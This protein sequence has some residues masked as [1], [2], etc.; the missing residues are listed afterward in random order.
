MMMKPTPDQKQQAVIRADACNPVQNTTTMRTGCLPGKG[1][2]V[3]NTMSITEADSRGS[4]ET[5]N[6]RYSQ[7][8]C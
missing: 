1:D 7:G 3:P 2:G 5:L 6:L 8:S 4:G